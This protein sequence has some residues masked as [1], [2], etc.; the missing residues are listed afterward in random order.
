MCSCCSVK[1]RSDLKIP[2][3]N[4]LSFHFPISFFL[5]SSG[6]MRYKDFLWNVFRIGFMPEDV[7]FNTLSA[8]F[9]GL[10]KLLSS[11][12]QTFRWHFFVLNFLAKNI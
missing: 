10:K 8:L 3:I 7:T 11:Y 12:F 4:L 5:F 1:W 6:Q 9:L 2:V